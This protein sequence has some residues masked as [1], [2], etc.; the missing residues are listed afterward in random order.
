M[1]RL[2]E[3][4]HVRHQVG[5]TL[6]CRQEHRTDSVRLQG[7]VVLWSCRG[8]RWTT[9]L[10]RQ[11]E[12]WC[13]PFHIA[14]RFVTLRQPLTARAG[15]LAAGIVC[16]L[17]VFEFTQVRQ[18]PY[19]DISWLV[20]ISMQCLVNHWDV[21]LPE[22]YPSARSCRGQCSDLGRGG[23]CSYANLGCRRDAQSRYRY[24]VPAAITISSVSPG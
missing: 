6:R 23:R 16:Q 11:A 19:S 1:Q 3:L 13:V 17:P 22:R 9:R 21:C 8:S 18:L 2:G 15:S 7:E 20:H 4:Q 5:D 14:N 10:W 24:P 12:H